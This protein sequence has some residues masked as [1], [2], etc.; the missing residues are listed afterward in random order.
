MYTESGFPQSL[1][2]PANSI[3]SNATVTMDISRTLA[4]PVANSIQFTPVTLFSAM[5]NNALSL[6]LDIA[7]MLTADYVS[8]FYRPVTSRD[9]PKALLA[10]ASHPSIPTHLQPTLP[11]IL[12]S[13][14]PYLDLLP[15]PLLRARLIVLTN[16]M[17]HTFDQFDFK[18]DI[19]INGGLVCWKTNGSAQPWDMRSWEAAPWFLRKW[20][21]LVD[22]ESGDIFK[23]SKWWWD[24]KDRILEAN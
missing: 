12:Y 22:G 19:Y 16:L 21:M 1:D 18:R 11:Q 6:G 20:R 9:D 7:K 5:M 10:S 15:Y 23:Q 3:T 2:I 13:H 8:P 14:H 17:P 4:N 24:L